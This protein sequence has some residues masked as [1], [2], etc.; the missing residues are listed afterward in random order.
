M[1]IE[2]IIFLIAILVFS[3]VVHEVSH[4]Y[5]AYMLG[6]PTAA[7]EGRLTLNPLKH[8]DLWGSFIVPVMLI[9]LNAGFVIGW[10]KPVPYNPFNL[11]NQRWGEAMVSGAGPLANAIIALVFA[12][13]IRVN[14]AYGIFPGAFI[15][16][17]AFV[18]YINILLAAFNLIP[19]PP[20]DGSKVF[21]ALLPKE[22]YQRFLAYRRWIAGYGMMATLLL[23]FLFIFLVWPF[24]FQGVLGIFSL[25][26][27]MPLPM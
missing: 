19:I 6:D 23:L 9:A 22:L 21:A 2:T 14:T 20:L 27:G 1:A 11:R 18:V 12:G 8:L 13:L 5:V 3:V 15:E 17:T 7:I 26:T 25:L 4:G 16:I 24:L 10:A